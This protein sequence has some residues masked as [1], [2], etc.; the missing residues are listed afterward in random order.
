M[1][2][3]VMRFILGTAHKPGFGLYASLGN[4]TV[5]IV[6]RKIKNLR[7]KTKNPIIVGLQKN[8]ISSLIYEVPNGKMCQRVYIDQIFEPI[9]RPW[10]DAHHDFVLEED[11]DSGHRPG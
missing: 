8:T 4:H 6:F 11:G 9:V 2:A 3:S 5:P 10:I 7:R 1:Y